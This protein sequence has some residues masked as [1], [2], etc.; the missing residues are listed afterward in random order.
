MPS[1]CKEGRK[2][3]SMLM[4]KMVHVL[5]KKMVHMRMLMTNY[6]PDHIVDTLISLAASIKYGDLSKYGIHRP[7]QG[8]FALKMLSRKTPVIDG[9]SVSRIKSKRIKV[10]INNHMKVYLNLSTFL[11]GQ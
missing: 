3:T 2:T 4:T 10:V 6:L 9:G 7:D 11:C 5:T 8:P 1:L